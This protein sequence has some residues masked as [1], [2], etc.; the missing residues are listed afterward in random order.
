MC[1]I[2]LYSARSNVYK[3][4]EAY[5]TIVIKKTNQRLTKPV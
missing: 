2:V 1:K 3:F 5:T 4:A